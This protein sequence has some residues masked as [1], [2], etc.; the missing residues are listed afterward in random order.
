MLILSFNYKIVIVIIVVLDNFCLIKYSFTY[1]VNKNE[2]CYIRLR[3]V[4]TPGILVG[5]I[6]E[7]VIKHWYLGLQKQRDYHGTAELK[8]GGC[9][10]WADS[11]DAVES[12]WVVVY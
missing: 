10:W 7:A 9:P 6:K 8:L 5:A 2:I 3:L 11:N 12:R 1:S 4:R